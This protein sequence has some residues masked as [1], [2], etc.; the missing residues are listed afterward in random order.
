LFPEKRTDDCLL[1]AWKILLL[2][3]IQIIRD[4]LKEGGEQSFAHFW[5]KISPEKP[6]FM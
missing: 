6:L 4:T 5:N 2:G 3:A 1:F